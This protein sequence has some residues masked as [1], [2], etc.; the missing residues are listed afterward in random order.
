MVSSV[1]TRRCTFRWGA[2]W[3]DKTPALVRPRKG[4]GMRARKSWYRLGIREES[5]PC[6]PVSVRHLRS[7]LK[8]TDPHCRPPLCSL[9]SL[10]R[11]SL[12]QNKLLSEREKSVEVVQKYGDFVGL[13]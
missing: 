5:V 10:M 13:P 2:V 7:G 11:R 1:K 3:D 8:E 12:K 9:A 6:C 4:L